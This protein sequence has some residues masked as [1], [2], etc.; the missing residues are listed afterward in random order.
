MSVMFQENRSNA[1]HTDLPHH[2][3]GPVIDTDYTTV[4]TNCYGVVHLLYK[5][6]GNEKQKDA[7][8]KRFLIAAVRKAAWTQLT[9]FH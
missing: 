1:K 4:H 6:R 9:L 5:N 8:V 7:R 3:F 2:L